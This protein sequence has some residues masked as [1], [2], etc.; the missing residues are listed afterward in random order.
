VQNESISWGTGTGQLMA[1]DDPADDTTADIWLHLNTGVPPVT[2]DTISGA[3]ASQDAGVDAIP[4]ATSPNH[5]GQFTGAW[6]AAE[7]IGFDAN[8]VTTTDSFRDVDGNPIN[9]PNFV[10]I[11]GTI[12]CVDAADDPHVFFT[13][14]NGANPN[15]Q[16]SVLATAAG[17]GA[18]TVE[19]TG[20]IPSNTPLTGWIG[21]LDAGGDNYT[22]YEY[23]S[24]SGSTYT[25]VG[26]LAEAYAVGD[27]LMMA[28]FYESAVGAGLVKS[29]TRSLIYDGTP[30][31]IIGWVRQGDE[32][33]P[34][35]VVPFSG[36]IGAGGY[37]FTANLSREV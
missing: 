11:T 22:F 4:L 19:I 25:L 18:N 28:Y 23:A 10:S 24:W 16:Q 3:A 1:F 29:V 32:A 34:D 35:T 2:G 12:N 33:A 7:G 8:Q 13:L 15:Y 6:L 27:D 30:I 26:T 14:R 37:T 31:D 9:P 36:Q 21:L 17:V 5:L 20:P